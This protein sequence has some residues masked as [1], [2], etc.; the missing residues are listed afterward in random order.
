[1][2]RAPTRAA[3]GGRTRCSASHR[4]VRGSRCAA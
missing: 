1:V 4:A 3:A 2:A